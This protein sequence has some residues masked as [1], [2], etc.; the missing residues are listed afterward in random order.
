MT[1]HTANHY[2]QGTGQVITSIT[3]NN[4]AIVRSSGDN[5]FLFHAKSVINAVKRGHYPLDGLEVYTL[6][7]E[8]KERL[9]NRAQTNI[10]S[11][12]KLTC[13]A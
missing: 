12:E 8:I 7:K 2:L 6:A 9:E 5:T 10:P 13:N 1:L 3:S 11:L 4:R